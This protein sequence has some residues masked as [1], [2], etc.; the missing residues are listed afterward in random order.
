[1][2]IGASSACR[3]APS[4]RDLSVTGLFLVWH[5][6]T[7]I[8]APLIWDGDAFPMSETLW[9]V[10]TPLDRSRL[11]HSIKKQ[12]PPGAALLVAPLTDS[13]GG[14]PKFKALAPGSL[15]WLKSDGKIED[16]APARGSEP[17]KRNSPPPPPFRQAE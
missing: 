2:R 9:L 3:E 8:G 7:G 11:Y 14:W 15:S 16:V 6:S 4:H 17:Q 1:M 10:R 5:G 12:L 13:P